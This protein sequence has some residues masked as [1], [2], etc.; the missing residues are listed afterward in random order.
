MAVFML[1][2]VI[3]VIIK[4]YTLLESTQLLCYIAYLIIHYTPTW[5]GL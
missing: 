5:V 1:F 4:G 2:Y 3:K